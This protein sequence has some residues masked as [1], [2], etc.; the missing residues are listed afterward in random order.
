MD[1]TMIARITEVHRSRYLIRTDAGKFPA[2]AAGRLIYAEEYPVVGD[3]VRVVLNEGSD[4]L[5]VSIEERKSLLVRPDRHGHADSYVG[6]M[7]EQTMAANLD[8]VFIVCSLNQN[9]NV[10]RIIRYA[11]I[12]HEG[13]CCPVAVLTKADICQN[14]EEYVSRLRELNSSLAVHCVSSYTGEGL[15][16][17]RSYFTPGTTIALLGSSGVGKSTLINTIAGREIMRVSAIR[18]EDAKGRH[19]TTHRQ[20]VELDGTDIIDTPG[21]RELG[22]CD[23][24]E[25]I[26]A[27]FEDIAELLTRCRFSDCSHH[28]E[29]GCAIRSALGDGSLSEEKWSLYC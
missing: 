5:I 1:Q 4:A 21:M 27:T 19:T 15:D 9:F 24:E 12:A 10:N 6:T 28:N 2:V 11:A 20:L 16:A 13:G 17:L 22:M 25:G 14:R 7:Q 23:V 26:N 18:E 8:Y 3:Y 29:P